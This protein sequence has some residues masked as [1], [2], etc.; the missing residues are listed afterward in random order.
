MTDAILD[1]QRITEQAYEQT[2]LTDFGVDSW[3]EGLARLVDALDREARLNELGR[4]IVG[5]EL[6]G[7]LSDR[8]RILAERR[9]DPEY[10]D[11]DVLPPIVLV[12]MGRTGT[13]ILHELLAQI[14]RRAC[15]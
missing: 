3:M 13:T 6:V 8:L 2:G 1:A 12:G 4:A 11:V 14:P 7:Y 5:G 9:A 10:A 15:R